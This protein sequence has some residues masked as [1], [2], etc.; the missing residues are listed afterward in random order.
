MMRKSNCPCKPQLSCEKDGRHLSRCEGSF[1]P[2][3][4]VLDRSL[5]VRYFTARLPKVAGTTEHCDFLSVPDM[6]PT[7][8]RASEFRHFLL[9]EQDAGHTISLTD[10]LLRQQR[11]V[12]LFTILSCC[13][14]FIY[15]QHATVRYRSTAR[16][17]VNQREHGL[18]DGNTS[19]RTDEDL[20]NEDILANH[21]ELLRSRRNVSAA[22]QRAGLS[23]LPSLEAERGDDQD[24]VDYVIENLELSRGG[25]GDSKAARSILLEFEHSDPADAMLVLDC[26]VSE[27]MLLI[28]EQFKDSL[29]IANRVVIDAQ[30]QIQ[31]ELQESQTAYIDLRKNAPVLFTGEGSSNVY[32]DQYRTLSTQ[33][34]NLEIEESTALGRLQKATATAEQYADPNLVMPL[35]ALGV[36]DT[37][38]LQR[39]GVFANMRADSTKSADFQMNQPERFEEA[40]AQYNQLLRL[41]LDKQRLEADFGAGHPDVQKLE[42]EIELVRSFLADNKVETDSTLDEPQLTSRQL[43][44]AYI[45]FLQSELASISERRTELEARIAHAESRARDLVDF[46][47]QEELLKSRIDRSQQLFDGLVEQ[48][49]SLDVAGSVDGY[50]HEIIETPR[51]GIRIWPRRS[52]VAAAGLALGLLGGVFLALINDHLDSRFQSVGEMDSLISLPIL[53][54]VDNLPVSRR[55]TVL[56]FEAP[57]SEA[58]RLLRT[59]LLADVRAGRLSSLSAAS[60]LSG[61]GKST[62]LLNIAASFAS[63]QMPVVLVEAD[64]RRP[65]LRKKLQLETKAGLADILTGK[66]SLEDALSSCAIP[67]LSVIHAGTAVSSPSEL[68]ESDSFDGLL[69]ELKT[70]FVLTI[71][72]VGPVLAVSDSLVVAQ[73]VD[74]TVLVVRPSADRRQQVFDAAEILRAAD[75]NLLGMVVNT[76]GSSRH[77]HKSRYGRPTGYGPR[78]IESAV[79]ELS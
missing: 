79:N 23:R 43:L 8:Q 68:L 40:R 2:P 71:V 65:V 41:M 46:E 54:C 44:G 5:S 11:I 7:R 13:L 28:E 37:E 45:G 61:D 76:C 48:L 35:E 57:E 22:L 26:I 69:K 12:I 74:G 31:A 67:H 36:I 16:V 59:M 6:A 19:S 73:K 51:M 21:I 49:R 62:I 78:L 32:V 14:A 15:L 17:M 18:I 27:Y 1:R 24:N 58:F 9:R 66:S 53:G 38:S 42:Q 25:K 50:L 72:D 56:N 60:A 77:F 55:A 47:L 4:A 70:R 52:L 29:A 75:V 63:L 3:F 10:A 39:L 20:V 64:M 34:V 33:L 30:N